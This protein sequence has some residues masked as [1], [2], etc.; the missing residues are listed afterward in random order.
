MAP[1]LTPWSDS[2][3][4]LESSN[5]D[6]E[7]DEQIDASPR[8]RLPVA[9]WVSVD[10]LEHVITSRPRRLRTSITAIPNDAV[11]KSSLD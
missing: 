6:D 7:E 4:E 9:M 1:P 11:G 10:A 3:E 2:N 5:D 8:K